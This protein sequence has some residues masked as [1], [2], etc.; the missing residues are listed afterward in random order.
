MTGYERQVRDAPESRVKL[1]V[2]GAKEAL[3]KLS[4]VQFGPAMRSGVRVE[5]FVD[6]L[7]VGD[8]TA[9]REAKPRKAPAAKAN[10]KT[11]R[12]TRR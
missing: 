11:G 8:T 2:K 3:E 4:E 10:K 5:D 12:R 9:G 6:R 1:H 7:L